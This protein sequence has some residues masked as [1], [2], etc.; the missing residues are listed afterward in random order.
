[1][2][3]TAP[4]P[5]RVGFV[6]ALNP[7]AGGVFQYSA[8]MGAALG[9][10]A[11]RD[12]WLSPVAV[13]SAGGEAQRS[14]FS[15][16]PWSTADLVPPSG[17]LRR[18]VGR[19]IGDGPLRS[20]ARRLRGNAGVGG[21]PAGADPLAVRRRPDVGTWW[22]SQRLDLMV[23]PQPHALAFEAG[24]PYVLAVHDLQ[25]RLQPEFREVSAGGEWITREYILRH[26]IA[27][28]ERILVDSELG[29]EHV[30]SFYAAYG[31]V[32]ERIDVLPFLPAATLTG[33]VPDD[34]KREVR[35]RLGVPDRFILYPAAFWPHKN[36]AR[37]IEALE[38]LR[39]TRNVS[40][41]AVF[42]G[43]RDDDGR[44]AHFA[45][46][47]EMARACGV[48]DQIHVP[49]YLPDADLAALYA[50]ATALVMP[51]FF[52]PTN[53]PVIEAWAHGCPVLTSD[54]PGIREQ[55]GDA[56]LLVD[57]KSVDAIAD[58]IH[59]LVTDPGLRS[60]LA[61]RGAGRGAAYT[62]ADFD[63]R[64]HASLRQ[65]ARPGSP[66]RRAP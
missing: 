32:R 17:A 22:R 9:R 63:E 60:D 28:A 62:P 37:V 35:T 50:S 45:F 29:R 64:L 10:I 25:H 30:L 55:V 23:F 66:A 24:L 42:C 48:A 6:P 7:H 2:P 12:S 58:G 53:I 38:Q 20:L 26:C 46:L 41:H 1:M 13:L 40:V 57:P 59:R 47:L 4:L 14:D 15:V 31:A 5:L 43:S 49:G 8:A 56:G 65:V 61:R 27:N 44:A 34:R 19:V 3:D 36:H 33:A 54:I 21:A 11:A 52:G 39:H 16:A 51:T 18:G